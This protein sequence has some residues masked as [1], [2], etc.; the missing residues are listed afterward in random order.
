MRVLVSGIAD[1]GVEALKLVLA[2]AMIPHRAARGSGGWELWVDDA[3]HPRAVQAIEA[4]LRDE[5]EADEEAPP[6]PPPPLVKNLSGIWIGLGL[7]VAHLAAVRSADPRALIKA[8]GASADAILSGELYRTVTALTLHGSAGHVASNMVGMAVFGTAVC[9]ITGR[10]VGW[11][12]ILLSGAAGNLLNAHFYETGHLSVG[13]STAVFG[14]IGVL[15]GQQFVTKI[16]QH[17]QR[18]RAWLPLG[19][20]LA[21][22]GF[23]GSSQFTDI[24]AHMFGFAAGLLF[25]AVYGLLVHRIPSRPIQVATGAGAA[26]VLALAWLGAWTL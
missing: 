4:Y 5:R 12:L 2:A 13:A 15:A 6:P 17:G 11:A 20:G 1:D 9:S 25:G 23:L 10:G 26:L 14:A 3:D 24:A 19:G 8:F 21:L 22:L 18:L 7:M 16:R